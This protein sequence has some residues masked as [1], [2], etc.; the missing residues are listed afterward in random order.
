MLP[1][2]LH[3]VVIFIALSVYTAPILIADPNLL[4]QFFGQIA[5]G[6]WQGQ[7]NMDFLF[8]L[9]LSALWVGWRHGF[10]AAGLGLAFLAATGGALFLSIYLFVQSFR[11]ADVREILVGR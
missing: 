11:C 1:L 6:G 7:F 9:T 5:D 4:P 8:M 2:R 10:T 3:C